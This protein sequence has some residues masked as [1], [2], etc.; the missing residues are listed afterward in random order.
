VCGGREALKKVL[1]IGENSYIGDSF[2]RFARDRFDIEVVDAKDGKWK[3]AD[4]SRFDSVLNCAGIAHVSQKKQMESLY[5]QINANLAE[6]L[7]RHCKEKGI[8]Q[9]IFLSSILIYG[10]ESGEITES[11]TPHPLCYYGKSKLFGE[12]LVMAL[13]DENFRVC[14]VRPPMVYGPDCKGNFPRLV[15]L[16][17]KTPIFP[18][19]ENKRSM[20]YID[21][22]CSFF[23]EIIE[24]E[25]SGVFMPQNSEYVNTTHLVRTIR[26]LHNQK[27]RETRIFNAPI[28]L[29]AR[30][31]SPLKKLFGSLTYSQSGSSGK[32][33]N[34]VGFRESIEN[35]ISKG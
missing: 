5:E 7:A 25:S 15:K 34:V 11:T 8:K 23:A 24:N 12:K 6:E 21:N 1:I 30:F 2:I 26:E 16:A 27:M 22:L 28:K 29:A 20:I 10:S 14:V 31:V 9:F 35:S 4:F 18:K 32:S 17:R 19:I 13:S 33:Y 3:K